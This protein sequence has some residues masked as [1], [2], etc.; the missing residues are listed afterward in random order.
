MNVRPARAADAEAI[1]NLVNSAYRGESSRFGWTTEADF[2]DG[3]R[4][5]VPRTLELIQPQ[6]G[7]NVLVLHDSDSAAIKGCVYVE[8]TSTGAYLGMLTVSPKLQDSGLGRILLEEAEKFARGFGAK[9]MTLGV[10]QLRGTLM[11]W[12]ERRG[13]RRTTETLPFPYDQPELGIPK[14]PDL[15]FVMFEKDL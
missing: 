5:S 2:L 15:H 1:C 14:R 6:D 10:I 13:Y 3:A 9:T 7:K 8:Q 4:I 11:A 12:Y